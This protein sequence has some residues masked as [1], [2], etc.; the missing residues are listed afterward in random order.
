[1]TFKDL[2]VGGRPYA[3][4][5]GFRRKTRLQL[6]SLVESD[7]KKSTVPISTGFLAFRRSYIASTKY[8]IIGGS[9]I[10]HKFET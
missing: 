2:L 8:V 3:A 10:E 9:N 6:G 7:D 5:L 4:V 1:M